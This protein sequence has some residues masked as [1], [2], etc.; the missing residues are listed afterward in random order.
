MPTTACDPL[1]MSRRL[2][3]LRTRSDA[4]ADALASDEAV[5]VNADILGMEPT[6]VKAATRLGAGLLLLG[7]TKDALEVYERGLEAHPDNTMIR[8][9]V[10]QARNAVRLGARVT[11]SVPRRGGTVA[12]RAPA[13][14]L[15]SIYHEP[16]WTVEP[17]EETWISDAGQVRADGARMYR[18]DGVPWGEPSWQVGDPVGLYFGGTFKVPILVEVAGP[19]RFDPEHV[20][21]Q[22]GLAEDAERWPWVTPIRGIAAVPLEDAPTLADLRIETT[23]MQQRARLLLDDDKRDR[24]LG[25]F[26]ASARAG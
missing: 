7:R 18:S 3:D 12:Q 14:W 13:G 1:R 26:G 16:G 23:S 5:A 20:R 4:L 10:A 17:G 22:T 2:E 6:D 25:L 21:E 24:L 8:N 9:R 19:P 15:K 11:A